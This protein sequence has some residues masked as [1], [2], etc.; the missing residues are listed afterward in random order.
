MLLKLLAKWN[1]IKLKN[2]LLI[3]FV[4]LIKRRL[5]TRVF[6]RE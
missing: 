3:A 2:K 6:R 5:H 1:D 4:F